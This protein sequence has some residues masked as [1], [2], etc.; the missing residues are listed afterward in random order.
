MGFEKQIL[1]TVAETLEPTTEASFTC[2]S[3]FVACDEAESETLLE[4]LQK[5]YTGKLI[6][7]GP[8]QGEYAYDFV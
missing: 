8:I 5:E 7:S 3:L 4:V 1:N 6:K 2:G